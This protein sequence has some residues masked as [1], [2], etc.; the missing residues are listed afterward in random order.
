MSG[1]LSGVWTAANVT[2]RVA[3]S[4]SMVMLVKS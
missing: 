4:Y 2:T 1:I 3:E